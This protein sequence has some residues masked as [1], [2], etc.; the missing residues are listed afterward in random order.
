MSE[1]VTAICLVG[2]GL[3]AFIAGLGIARMPDVFIRMHAATKAG[4]LGV[5]LI[6]AAVAVNFAD[7]GIAVRAFAGIAFLIITA[8]VAAH[9]IG[10]A[11]YGEGV[12]LWR[13]TAIDEWR[14]HPQAGAQAGRSGEER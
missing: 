1:I 11:A 9:L 8:P 4:T 13:E 12:P 2:G 14:G 6:M 5:G 7:L 3:F 10:R